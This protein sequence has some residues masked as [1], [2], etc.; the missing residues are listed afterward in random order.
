MQRIMSKVQFIFNPFH[1]L[2]AK[3]SQNKILYKSV[4][5]VIFQAYTLL[6]F[7]Q[8]SEK[9]RALIFLKT[10]TQETSFWWEY[11][12]S[13]YFLSPPFNKNIYINIHLTYI[14]ISLSLSLSIYLY[15]SLYISI[16]PPVPVK[17]VKKI[18]MLM[19]CFFHKTWKMWDLF[20]PFRSKNSW[21]S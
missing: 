21:N 4:V 3:K 19:R 5:Q 2:S 18:H 10:T 11:F 6:Q 15:L 13:P 20:R 17:T 12:N 14:H 8:K 16:R 1:S 7:W 9:F